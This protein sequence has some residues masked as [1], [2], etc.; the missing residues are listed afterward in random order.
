[1]RRLMVALFAVALLSQAVMTERNTVPARLGLHVTAEEL[2][3][4]RDRAVKG[5]YKVRGDVSTNSPGDWERIIS[6][7]NEFMADPAGVRWRGAIEETSGTGCVSRGDNSPASDAYLAD[8]WRLV[9]TAFYAIVARDQTVAKAVTGELLAQIDHEDTKFRER[10]RYCL[11]D[12]MLG[13]ESPGFK[14]GDRMMSQLY[15]VDYM[16]IAQTENGWSLFTSAQQD[17]LRGWFGGFAE[18][19]NARRSR[20]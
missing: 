14:M 12:G 2:A 17:N 5:P 18:W 3:I 20:G 16:L 7:K 6:S 8:G 15:A 19:A 4:W 10:S 13:D 9:D 11:N 1:M